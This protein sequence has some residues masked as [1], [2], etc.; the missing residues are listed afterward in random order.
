MATRKTEL[1]AL[2]P[3]PLTPEPEAVER[4][5]LALQGLG[6][7]N[8]DLARRAAWNQIRLAGARA[9]S[10]PREV[11]G[12]LAR[13]FALGVVPDPPLDGPCSGI[14]VAP[15]LGRAA[16]V[17]FGVV[18]SAW[19]PWLGKRFDR[20]A[21]RG[22]NMLDASAGLPMRVL[23]P[24]YRAREAGPGRLAAFSFRTYIAPGG[25]EPAVDSLTIDYDLDENPAFLIRGIRDEVVQ[26]VRGAYLGRALLRRRGGSG[27]RLLGYFALQPPESAPAAQPEAAA[28]GEV[29]PAT[30]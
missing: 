9:R 25:I 19:M 15:A 22:E 5:V 29:A 28:T 17:A 1:P 8:A 3:D 26:M 23:W 12:T 21:E 4:Y 16:D 6:K 30:A 18:G 11:A 27:W 20:E 7:S 2:E 10:R 14:P 24:G 13:L